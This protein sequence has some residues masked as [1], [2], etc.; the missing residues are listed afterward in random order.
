MDLNIQMGVDN[1]LDWT[2]YSIHPPG[3]LFLL[4]EISDACVNKFLMAF[5]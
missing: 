3:K 5:R 2:T 4:L 1:L